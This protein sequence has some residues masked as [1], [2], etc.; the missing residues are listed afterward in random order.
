MTLSKAICLTEVI[1]SVTGRCPWAVL[2]TWSDRSTALV[3]S[4]GDP[5][6]SATRT[7]STTK[8]HIQWR[9]RPRAPCQHCRIGSWA[10]VYTDSFLR[11]PSRSTALLTFNQYSNQRSNDTSKVSYR[12]YVYVKYTYRVWPNIVRSF[13]PLFVE[14]NHTE[15]FDFVKHLYS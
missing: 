3:T 10:L 8:A 14:V 12:V 15:R 13:K 11:H 4:R 7:L 1:Y 2:A 5:V 9:C 6:F